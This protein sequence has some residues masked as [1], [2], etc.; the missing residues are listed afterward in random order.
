MFPLRDEN[1]TFHTS[2]ATMAIIA[3]NALVWI[4][5]QGLGSEPRLIQSVCSLGLIPA[6]LLRT[7]PPGTAIPIAERYYCVIEADPNWWTLLTSMFLHGS[8]GHII[9][10]MWFL[11]VFGDNVEDVMGPIRF[12]VFY[13]LCGLAAAAAQILSNPYSPVPMVGASGAIGG[14]MGAYAILYP[15]H[16]V[17]TLVFFGF[18]ARVIYLPAITMLGY[19]FLLQVLGTLWSFG[20]ATGGVAFWAH[21]GGF[22]AGIGLVRFFLSPERVRCCRRRRRLAAWVPD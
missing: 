18:F 9:G 3:A 4:F 5:V 15:W 14:V 12:T 20:P 17:E 2:I 7:L 21:I 13:L 1:P 19:W 10:N 8:W 16:R 6:E 11:W 22:L